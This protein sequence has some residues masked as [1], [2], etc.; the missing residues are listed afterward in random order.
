MY[1]VQALE[2]ETLQ[3]NTEKRIVESARQLLT[4]AGLDPAQ[5]LQQMPP[6]SQEIV[7]KKF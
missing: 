3:G 7:R 6:E 5:L 4:S 1:I 2:A